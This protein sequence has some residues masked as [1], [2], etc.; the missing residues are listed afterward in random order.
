MKS[1]KTILEGIFDQDIISK[2]YNVL[3]FILKEIL[4]YDKFDD[5]ALKSVI[6]RLDE[7]FKLN[8]K[9]EVNSLSIKP[10]TL[11]VAYDNDTVP[12]HIILMAKGLGGN[13]SKNYILLINGL[14]SHFNW[15]TNSV[16]IDQ[17]EEE[18]LSWMNI[19]K[20]K[21]YKFSIYPLSKK[22]IK[23]FLNVYN[24]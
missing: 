9:V 16:M 3:D 10:N 7:V 14:W 6:N 18:Y 2:D 24:K 8:K 13:P 11:Y 19:F 5:D 1:L 4:N 12:H 21:K 23:E 22:D 20:M 15:D 17:S